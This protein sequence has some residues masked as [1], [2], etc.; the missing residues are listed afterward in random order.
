MNDKIEYIRNIDFSMI[1]E[2]MVVHRGWRRE[3]AQEACRLYRNF[4]ILVIKYP[5]KTLPPS[6]DIDE[7]WHYHI[8]DSKKYRDDCKTLFGGHLDHYPYIGI[9]GKTEM[10]DAS[11][12]FEEV[13][14]LHFE[15]F[16]EYIY[17]VRGRPFKRFL[18]KFFN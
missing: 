10:S 15:E 5:D 7:F 17:E 11:N 4:L 18:S 16:G 8:L 3:D 14:R 1:I 12:T 9:D 13:Q 2:K 6:E